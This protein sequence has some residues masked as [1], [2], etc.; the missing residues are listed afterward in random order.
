M[1]RRTVVAFPAA[2]DAARVLGQQIKSARHER[3][4]T[5]AEFAER[6]GVSPVTVRAIESGAPGTA[7]GTVFNAAVLAGVELFGTD[8]KAE[9]ARLRH[10]G[11]ERLNLMPQRVRPSAPKDDDGLLDF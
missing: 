2:A 4:W 3:R 8:D 11:E 10:R 1:P 9:L 5:A 7:I 6:L